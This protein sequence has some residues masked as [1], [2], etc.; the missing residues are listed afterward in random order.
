[1]EFF[2][3]EGLNIYEYYKDIYSGIVVGAPDVD[4]RGGELDCED[5]VV[6]IDD[7]PIEKDYPQYTWVALKRLLDDEKL[8]DI[9]DEEM[10]KNLYENKKI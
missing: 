2:S 3:N 6:V 8:I 9:F 5:C 10:M 7:Y 4:N 1:M